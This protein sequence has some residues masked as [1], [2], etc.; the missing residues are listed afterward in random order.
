MKR[1]ASNEKPGD[2]LAGLFCKE[3]KLVKAV[4]LCSPPGVERFCL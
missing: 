4:L 3:W 1:F 2:L